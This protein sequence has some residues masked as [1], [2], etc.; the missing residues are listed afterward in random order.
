MNG[1]ARSSILVTG[2]L[3]SLGLAPTSGP[4][5][6][7]TEPAH[8]VDPLPIPKRLHVP[9]WGEVTIK[10]TQ[11]SAKIHRDLPPVAQW[12]Y[13]GTSPGPTIEVERGQKLVVHWKNEL[14]AKHIYPLPAH[15]DVISPD[16]R[17]V[18]HLHGAVVSEPEIDQLVKGPRDHSRDNDGWPDAWIVNGQE[19][20]A[21]YPNNESARTLWYHDH[22]MGS[23]GRNVA[24]GLLGTYEIHDAYERSLHL[25]S[26]SHDIP[27]MFEPRQLNPDGTLSYTDDIGNE[28]YGNASEVNG[29]LWPYLEVEPRKYRF[30][31]VNSSNAR[32]L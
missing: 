27:L 31:L 2:L 11:I 7:P 9:P 1:S 15:A 28:Y 30:R 8:F 22:A 32:I 29:K 25:P 17:T 14:P 19:Q 18:T 21:E 12:A 13:D 5:A 20:I 26:G 4:A 24:A 3:F 6:A 10:E 23:T 16:V